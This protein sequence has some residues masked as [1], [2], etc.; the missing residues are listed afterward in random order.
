MPRGGKRQGAGRKAGSGKYAEATKS[1]RVP[2]SLEDE[3]AEFLA[4]RGHRFPLYGARAAAG[5]PIGGDDFIEEHVN[6]HAYLGINGA[7]V[8]YVRARGDSMVDA[9]ILDG[10]LLTVDTAKPA[11]SGQVVLASLGAEQTV[12]RLLR[13]GAQTWL[14]PENKKYPPMEITESSQLHIWGVV[15]GAARRVL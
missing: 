14:L 12:K 5:V 3:V 11:R 4:S 10:D 6:L 2:L 13:K 9:G 15:T 7:G 8:A 1:M